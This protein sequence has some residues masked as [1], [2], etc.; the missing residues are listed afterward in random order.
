MSTTTQLSENSHQGFEGLKAALY[1]ASMEAKSNAASDLPLR[2]RSNGIR[3]RCTGK[4]RDTETGLDYF[5]ARYY[6]GAQG[7]FT[8]PDPDN[9]DARLEEPQSW[10]MYSYTWNSPL[11]Y[12]DSDGRAVNF[13]FAAAGFAGGYLLSFGGNA[14]SQYRST[15]HVDWLSAAKY[16]VGGDISGAAAGF[17]FGLTLVGAGASVATATAFN[18]AGGATSRGL[19]GED[20]FDTTG[21]A[22]DVGNGIIGGTIGAATQGLGVLANLPAAPK[23]LYTV[24]AANALKRLSKIRA[25]QSMKSQLSDKYSNSGA[26]LGTAFTNFYTQVANPQRMMP[27]SG[28]G[29]STFDLFDQ[30]IRQHNR[31]TCGLDTYCFGRVSVRVCYVGTGHCDSK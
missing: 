29:S 16:G 20:I 12:V 21:M 26:A 8:S 23:P 15:G 9:Y 1:L 7:R 27:Y 25:Y 6:S 4:E 17:T 22:D 28:S 10:N 11:K 13:G 3:S 14:I 5:G 2:L 30:I 19:T 24:R 18:V 31:E